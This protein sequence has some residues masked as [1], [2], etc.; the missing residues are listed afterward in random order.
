MCY[1]QQYNRQK[2]S[3]ETFEKA[4]IK[5]VKNKNNNYVSKK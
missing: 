1:R 4:G 3:M 2:N 5:F